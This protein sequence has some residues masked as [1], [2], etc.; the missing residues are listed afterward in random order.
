MP[1]VAVACAAATFALPASFASIRALHAPDLMKPT[2][3]LMLAAALWPA[4]TLAASDCFIDAAAYQHV[5]PVVLRAIAWQESHAR[6]DAL[7]RNSNGTVDYG[8]M[9]I[10]SIHLPALSRYGLSA[11]DLMKP[12]SSV[13]IAAWYLHSMMNKYGNT[14][15]AVGAYHSQSPAERDRYAHAIA[16]I[17]DQLQTLQADDD[18]SM[19]R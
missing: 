19:P 7:H 9:Q 5:S 17:V 2:L 3:S 15:Q 1:L 11:R 18:V 8:I 16:A 14:W 4:S 6:A 10:N 13:Y 12:C